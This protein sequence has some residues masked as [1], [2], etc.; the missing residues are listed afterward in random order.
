MIKN[1][2]AL[3]LGS[4]CLFQ[5][6]VAQTSTPLV[7]TADFDPIVASLDSLVTIHNVV[8]Y[9]A[10]STFNTQ[11]GGAVIPQFSDEVYADRISKINTTIPLTYN[12]QVKGYID[13]Y[14]TKKR[15]LTQ[16]VMGLSNLYF[17]MFE[18]VLEREGLP[19]E[20]K[21]LSVV[22]SALN[23]LAVSHCGATGLWQF[24]YNTGIM[25]KLAVTTQTDDRRDPYKSTVAA[26]QY[27]KAMYKIYNDWLLVIASYNCGPGNVNKAIV[28]S[29]GK[30]DFWSI[31][32]Y[33][34][35]E[36]RGY[37]PAFI[38]VTYLMNHT[39][40]HELTAIAPAITY[41]E[42]DTVKVFNRIGFNALANALQLPSDVIAFLN[43]TY[44]KGYVPASVNGLPNTLRLP[45]TKVAAFIQNQALLFEAEN[46]LLA[47]RP[48]FSHLNKK[49]K[50][51]TNEY[52]WVTR[53]VKK[54][55]VVRRGESLSSIANKYNASTAEI[56][57]LNKLRSNS[58]RQGQRLYV[59]AE[60][61]VAVKKQKTDTT[62]NTLANNDSSIKD[63][64]LH[65]IDYVNGSAKAKQAILTAN[66]MHPNATDLPEDFL[67]SQ[68][69]KENVVYHLVQ[70]GD[71]LY[72]IAR[73]Q[74][75]SVQELMRYNGFAP[76]KKL[77][78]GEKI[79]VKING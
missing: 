24:M 37:V 17:P 68:G 18:E 28:R 47:Q 42:T 36:T 20:F 35:A 51:N 75:I 79:K 45:T 58:V 53:E 3:V 8:N 60:Q 1:I 25:Y 4:I 43:P 27:F 33:L 9:Q 64:A 59:M 34:P 5:M 29:G 7:Q 26:C 38:A 39:T 40:A 71:T 63:S 14:A 32:P 77:K 12:S 76:N 72:G 46:K 67:R 6:A 62:N 57:K 2:K 56:K 70:K 16:R 78:A 13:L 50:Y 41:F 66:A 54:T 74:G 69:V 10:Q 21:Y 22:E 11:Q 15:N 49:S 44:K 61:Q 52:D 73:A 19:L 55:H 65:L 30:T 31:S 48:D 23:P